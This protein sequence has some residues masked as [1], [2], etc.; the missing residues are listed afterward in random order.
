[1][2]SEQS[3]ILFLIVAVSG[4]FAVAISEWLRRRTLKPEERQAEDEQ[5]RIDMAEW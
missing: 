3:V 4:C 5:S 1:M 2:W